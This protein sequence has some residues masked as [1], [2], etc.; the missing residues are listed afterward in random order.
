MPP[1]EITLKLILHW[2]SLLRALGK[3]GT[4]VKR[5]LASLIAWISG[6]YLLHSSSS[7]QLQM[8]RVWI[9]KDQQ[10]PVSRTSCF[11]CLDDTSVNEGLS[12]VIMYYPNSEL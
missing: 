6:Q 3:E 2:L 4:Q 12:E 10:E 7:S 11:P 8:A 1:G 9:N 5:E